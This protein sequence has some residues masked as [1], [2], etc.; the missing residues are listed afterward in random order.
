MNED[1]DTDFANECNRITAKVMQLLAGRDKDVQFAVLADLVS[2][3]LIGHRL[4]EGTTLAT[5]RVGLLEDFTGMVIRM[6]AVNDGI[7]AQFEADKATKQ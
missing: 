7:I 4:P 1:E 3:W 2:I 6:I 5:Y